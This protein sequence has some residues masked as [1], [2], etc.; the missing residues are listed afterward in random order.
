MPTVFSQAQTFYGVVF[1]IL[2]FLG[3]VLSLLFGN[4]DPCRTRSVLTF[5]GGNGQFETYGL[6]YQGRE[7]LGA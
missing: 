1:S 6:N 7:G 4:L 3:Q 5:Y 2:F